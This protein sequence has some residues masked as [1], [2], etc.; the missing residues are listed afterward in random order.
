VDHEAV[1]VLD[2]VQV[3]A[4]DDQAAILRRPLEETLGHLGATGIVH[5]RQATCAQRAGQLAH[6]H[7]GDFVKEEGLAAAAADLGR[8]RREF[9]DVL[10][11]RRVGKRSNGAVLGKRGR[12][13]PTGSAL[14]ATA[15]T[16]TSSSAGS[17][18]TAATTTS[19]TATTASSATASSATASSTTSSAK[20]SACVRDDIL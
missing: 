14:T 18:A 10:E 2:E 4:I 15:A 3:A 8:A 5:H 16:T 1:A 20:G 7:F 13:P 12:L 6:E 17:T 19:S 9:L 11:F